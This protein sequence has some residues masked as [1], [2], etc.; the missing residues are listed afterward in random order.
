MA[1]IKLQQFEGPLDL[2]LSLIEDQKLNI[3]D[4]ALAEVTEQFLQYVKDLEQIE[5]TALADYL[6]IAAKLLVIKSKAILPSLEVTEDDEAEPEEDLTEKLILYKQ[7]KEVARFLKQLDAKR[8]QSFTRSAIFSQRINFFPDPSITNNSLHSAILQVLQ[9][10]K[11]LDS[12]PKARVKEAVSIQEKISHLQ[13]RLA[14]KIE[15]SLSELLAEAKNKDE[16]IV[17]FL[18][19][20]ELIKQQIFSVEQELLFTDVKIKRYAPTLQKPEST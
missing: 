5:A 7:F 15:T 13:N 10:L 19:L 8:Q 20:L 12:L 2:L 17:T 3:T 18:A 1:K 16:V 14:N 9:Q 4:I 6:N 11:E